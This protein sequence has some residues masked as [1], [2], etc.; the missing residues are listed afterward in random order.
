MELIVKGYRGDEVRYEQPANVERDLP[1][2]CRL[3][4][5]LI[6]LLLDSVVYGFDRL[7]ITRKEVKEDANRHEDSQGAEPL[8]GLRP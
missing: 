3:L 2:S 6:Y 1:L 5:R 8:S 4:G 7:E